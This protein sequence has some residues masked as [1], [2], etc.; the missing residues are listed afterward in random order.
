VWWCKPI[1]PSTWEAETG[2]S[3]IQA[4]LGYIARHCLKEKKKAIKQ[5]VKPCTN[6][7]SIFISNSENLET[8][9][10]SFNK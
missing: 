3:G 9:W 8:T 5:N 2:G 4:S 1:N 6:I 10:M 7:Y